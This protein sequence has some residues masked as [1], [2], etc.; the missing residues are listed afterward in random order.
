MIH[1]ML[2]NRETIGTS[3]TDLTLCAINFREFDSVE[4][5]IRARGRSEHLVGGD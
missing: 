3:G 4:Q 2:V 5:S 1:L